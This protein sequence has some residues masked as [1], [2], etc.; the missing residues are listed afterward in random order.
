MNHHIALIIFYFGPFPSYF[1]F[2][3]RSCEMNPAVHWHIYTDNIQADNWPANVHHHLTSLEE[4]KR[5]FQKK[6]D[7]EISL[8]NPKKLCDYKPFYGYLLEEELREYD[9]WGHCDLDQIFGQI[10]IPEELLATYDRIYSLGHFS[11]YRNE[12][13]VN[14]FLLTYQNGSRVQE[15]LQQER[16]IAFDEWGEGNSNDIFLKSDISFY[17]RDY[18]VDIWPESRCFLLSQY[19]K[20]KNRY[21]SKPRSEGI[22]YWESGMLYYIYQ[23]GHKEEISYAHMQKRHL[24]VKC[25][26]E[27][28]SFYITPEGFLS[29]SLSLKD[30]M[31]KALRKPL[32][33]KQFFKIKIRNI[34]AR[35]KVFG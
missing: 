4:T 33:D 20:E 19:N 22:L 14:T 13:Y 29:G 25:M 28:N 24:E 7:Y 27:E 15:V 17:P 10:D 18:G 2:F 35:L 9:F 31:R 1:P 6:F 34:R 23:D 12:S 8:E 21:Y 30:I 3:L 11:L 16:Q 26:P 5:R 32:F